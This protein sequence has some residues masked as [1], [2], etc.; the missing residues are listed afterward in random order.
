[1]APQLSS[2]TG[3]QLS[4]CHVLNNQLSQREEI[5][6]NYQVTRSSWPIVPYLNHAG[7]EADD[8]LEE[9][10]VSQVYQDPLVLEHGIRLTQANI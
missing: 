6:Y 5:K 1:M 8:L 4:G 2:L 9:R 7:G 3:S 10:G